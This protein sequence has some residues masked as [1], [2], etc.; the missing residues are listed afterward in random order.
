[1]KEERILLVDGNNCLMRAHFK[2]KN[3]WFSNGKIPTSAVYGF[4]KILYSNIVRFKITSVVVCFDCHRSKLRTDMYPEYKAH[5]KRISEDWDQIFKVQFPIIKRILRNLGIVYVWDNKRINEMESDDY[6]AL[7]YQK[8]CLSQVYL[9]SSD[10]DFVQ[11][12]A[13]PNIKLINPSKDMLVTPKNCKDV[14]GY[15]PEQAVDMKIL[16]GDTSDNI[17]GIKGVGPKTALKFLEEYGSIRE[18]LKS[19]HGDKKFPKSELEPIFKRNQLLIDLFYYL[20]K[21]NPEVI[22]YH[23]KKHAMDKITLNGIF[24]KYQLKSFMS[25]EFMK[26]FKQLKTYKYEE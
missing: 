4:F 18:F 25:S 11:L 1:M 6:L 17:S 10:E 5:R 7:L 26:P 15:T 19:D 21:V 3:K 2:F 23:D 20:T 9:L 8:N 12:L 13:F 24:E 14:Y 16:C 22:P